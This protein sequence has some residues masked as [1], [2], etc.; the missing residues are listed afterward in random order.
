MG[1]SLSI[2]SQKILYLNCRFSRT[3]SSCDLGF[4][5]NFNFFFMINIKLYD[6]DAFS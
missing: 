3:R 5:M 6:Y 1:C 4:L 2:E